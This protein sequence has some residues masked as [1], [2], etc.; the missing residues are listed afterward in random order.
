MREK[1]DSRPDLFL[2]IREGS[3][4]SFI[5]SRYG[6]ESGWKSSRTQI[7]LRRYQTRR[8]D[9]RR[10][11][12]CSWWLNIVEHS[13]D[14]RKLE[15]WKFEG[16]FLSFS[17]PYSPPHPSWHEILIWPGPF[18]L[19]SLQIPCSWLRYLQF[20]H[21]RLLLLQ[22][23]HNR[24]CSLRNPQSRLCS[25]SSMMDQLPTCAWLQSSSK[26]YEQARL[27]ARFALWNTFQ[28]CW[29]WRSVCFDDGGRV[30]VG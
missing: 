2:L 17:R 29:A 18:A 14:C 21:S 23:Q 15:P 5:R 19:I 3:F 24:L 26:S 9:A 28:W 4:E 6:T 30:E 11:V 20:Q 12:C 8:D 22:F 7:S 1:I 27:I 25:P 10:V 16:L 13:H